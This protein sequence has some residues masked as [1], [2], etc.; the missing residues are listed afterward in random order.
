MRGT[1][2]RVQVERVPARTR[3]PKV[4][5]LWWAGLRACSWISTLPGGRMSAGSTR[6]TPS[7]SA[8]RPSAGPRPVRAIPSRLTAGPGWCWPPTPNCA[9]PRQS[10]LTSD[11]RGNDPAHRAGSAPTEC[12][13]GFRGCCAHSARR[14]PRRNP[15][16]VPPAGRRAGPLGLLPAT[17]RSRSPL[18][19]CP[20]P[21]RPPE[22]PSLPSTP[23]DHGRRSARHARR[24]K[25]Q[26]KTV[27]AFSARLRDEVDLDALGAELLAVVDQTMQ[28]TRASLWLQP[29]AQMRPGGKGEKASHPDGP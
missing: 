19:S 27:E 28:P 11:C 6:S 10:S 26:A 20:R 4:L 15:A 3:P 17:R 16:D 29:S 1:I 13:A 8:S 18:R 2:L 5:W 12:A 7:G 23:A 24:V 25:S 9:W 22:R 14:L 21:P